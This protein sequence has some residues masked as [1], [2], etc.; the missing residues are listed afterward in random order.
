MPDHT[1]AE[2]LS[3][4]QVAKTDIKNA[5]ITMGGAA[6]PSHGLEDFSEDILT[7]PSGSL[8]PDGKYVLFQSNGST[9][10]GG[11]IQIGIGSYE[12]R[13]NTYSPPLVNGEKTGFTFSQ[14]SS[15]SH[16]IPQ[17]GTIFGDKI[18][19][20]LVIPQIKKYY[21]YKSVDVG[22]H[23]HL[24]AY[25]FANPD[26]A[27]GIYNL[28]VV[29]GNITSDYLDYDLTGEL[30]LDKQYYSSSYYIALAI[31]VITK[32]ALSSSEWYDRAAGQCT[33]VFEQ[34]V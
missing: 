32:I 8:T 31:P 29:S 14:L 20:S 28:Q 15:G 26:I 1:I 4:L 22:E 30:F 21:D 19:L 9:I 25:I 23:L 16:Y 27:H 6:D 5:I 3:R 7:I 12:S 33:I 24:Y 10:Y 2:N 17:C 18:I 13:M 34:S 11:C